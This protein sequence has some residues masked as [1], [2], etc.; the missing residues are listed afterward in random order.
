MVVFSLMLDFL[1]IRIDLSLFL[2][3]SYF[4]DVI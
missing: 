3:I 1:F 2:N 4:L